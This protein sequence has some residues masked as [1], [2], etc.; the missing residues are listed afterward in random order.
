MPLVVTT[1]RPLI[2]SCEPGSITFVLSVP[3][4][5]SMF[6]FSLTCKISVFTTAPYS[7]ERVASLPSSPTS[8]S[9]V[10]N[11][12]PSP[13]TEMSPVETSECAMY[14]LIAVTVAPLEMYS[15][16]SPCSP[17]MSSSVVSV[18]LLSTFTVLFEVCPMAI[19]S[20]FV[21]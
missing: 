19:F 18:A 13:D 10:L 1:P 7:I 2:F 4:R 6:P 9:Y 5:I 21:A 14:V 20:Q 15:D 11:V 16:P 17:T 8:N 3:Y 12:E